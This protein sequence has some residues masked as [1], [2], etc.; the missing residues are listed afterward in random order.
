MKIK[1]LAVYLIVGAAFLAVSLWVFLSGGKNAKA[2]RYKFK[3]GGI[4][5]TAWSMLSAASCEGP[6]TPSVTCYEPVPSD[7]VYV[8][9]PDYNGECLN[10][11]AG[12]VITVH[13]EFFSYKKFIIK[14]NA[15]NL[16]K[17]LLQSESCSAAGNDYRFE[18]NLT[19]GEFDYKGKALLSTYG[20]SDKGEE[21]ELG[22]SFL[23]N[24]L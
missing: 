21:I 24:I 10:V 7:Y 17:T 22:Y 14:I 13:F 5:L 8:V 15:D 16:D 18:H 3:L 9:A 11:K 2:I 20:V 12:D 1:F 6:I 19:V 4:V 23:M